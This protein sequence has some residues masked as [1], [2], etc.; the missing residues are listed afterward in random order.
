MYYNGYGVTK[1]YKK[2][3]EWYTKAAEQGDACAQNDLGE[4]CFEGEG[5]PQNSIEAYIWSKLAT[6][7][8]HE[9][10]THLKQLNKIAATL[11][12]SDI[13][14]ADEIYKQRKEEIRLRREKAKLR[15]HGR[16]SRPSKAPSLRPGSAQDLIPGK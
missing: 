3:F 13:Q 16:N 15:V 5:V 2:G 8:D 10:Q 6:D 9:G 1:D 7:N 4:R 12:E 11:S 14:Q